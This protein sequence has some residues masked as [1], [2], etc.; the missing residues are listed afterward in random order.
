VPIN[1]FP[2]SNPRPTIDLSDDPTVTINES[3]GT[4]TVHIPSGT[5]HDLISDNFPDD[6][7]EIPNIGVYSAAGDVAEAT[8]YATTALSRQSDGDPSRWRPYPKK[9]A[10]AA[11]T[12]AIPLQEGAQSIQVQTDANLAGNAGSKEII[13]HSWQETQPMSGTNTDGST[14]QTSLT[15]PH[16]IRLRAHAHDCF[17]DK[18][19]N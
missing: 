19:P 11:M 18:L 1:Y 6:T 15:R 5:V 16:S 4:I 17:A 3:A 13:V 12:A 7:A 10:F 2:V 9:F 14:I 8:A